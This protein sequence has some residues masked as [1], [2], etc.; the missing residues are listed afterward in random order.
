MIPKILTIKGLY[1]YSE[2]ATINFERLSQAHIF[3]IFGNVGSGKSTILEAMMLALYGEVPRLGHGKGDNRNFNMMNLKSNELSVDFEFEAAGKKYKS[4]VEAKRNVKKFE[5][6]AS[7][8]FR[9]YVWDTDAQAWTPL[10]FEP[11]EVIGLKLE[12]FTKTIIVPQNQ[13]QEFLQ[14]KDT[15]RSKM[16]SDLFNLERFD[17][18]KKATAIENRNKLKVAE[19]EFQLGQL[20]DVTKEKIDDI[21]TQLAD[22]ERLTADNATQLKEK[23]QSENAL[24]QLKKQFDTLNI[25]KNRLDE[26]ENRTPQYNALEKQ[27]LDFEYCQLHFQ[28]LIEQSESAAKSVAENT[29]LLQQNQKE[30]VE[31]ERVLT[32]TK[33]LHKSLQPQFDNRH[34]R[35]REA[36]ELSHIS[37][38]QKAEKA[39][40]ASSQRVE[41]GNIAVQ[42]Q[43]LI[44]EEL[45]TNRSALEAERAGLKS[46]NFI[47][48]GDIK[49]WF[50]K[51]NALKKEK[52]TIE[53]GITQFTESLAAIETNRNKLVA[54]DLPFFGEKYAQHISIAEALLM[55][56]KGIDSREKK[57]AESN[58]KMQ[59]ELAV[60]ELENLATQLNDGEPCPLCGSVHHPELMNTTNVQRLVADIEKE[61]AAITAHIKSL[62]NIG[63][64]L[65]T[66]QTMFIKVTQDRK[67]LLQQQA[68]KQ[69]EIAAH[70][71]LFIW[72]HF[73]KT[74][75]EAVN[76]A[77]V[78]ADLLVKRIE[79]LNKNVQEKT[80]NI[81]HEM[82][83][84]D[85]YEVVINGL[86]S[87]IAVNNGQKQ[88]LIQQ[89]QTL[90][91]SDFVDTTEDQ[92]LKKQTDIKEAVKLLALQFAEVEK[93]LEKRA[94]K[95]AILR[96]GIS[97]LERNKA[98][99]DAQLTT[100][101]GALEARLTAS[102]FTNLDAVKTI[103]TAKINVEFEKK[104]LADFRSESNAAKKAHVE[105]ALELTPKNY[106]I[107]NH[108]S[109]ITD[110]QELDEKIEHQNQRIGGLKTML[111]DAK[112]KL[113]QRLALEKE[114]SALDLRAKNISELK[115]LFYASGFVS[116]ASTIYLK[117]L[118]QNA[119]ERFERLTNYRLRLEVT[120]DNTFLVSD[121]LNDGKTR[122]VKTLSGGQT[123]QAALSLA[124]ALADN[125]QSLTKSP[126][127]FFF[128]DE[129]FG[130]LDKDSLHV[131]FETLKSLRRENRIVG[132]ISHVEEMQQEI[133]H[134]VRVVLDEEKG[135]QLSYH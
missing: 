44:I 5:E 47:E 100:A 79:E 25:L 96:G 127:N 88:T 115:R 21:K 15:E 93:Q 80:K 16:M 114:R 84:L 85:Q 50:S 60:L 130:S 128:L 43:R 24:T 78:N 131:V 49:N 26:F 59:H 4:I 28:H 76:I 119:N 8:R 56:K 121:I 19:N 27:L 37:T 108:Q 13:F 101:S 33:T 118:I 116:Y 29:A 94:E 39:I 64:Q 90:K 41:K 57:I 99:L 3:G 81:E 72:K 10:N 104:R 95:A 62:Q 12:H 117:S 65:E 40:L 42:K 30:F 87:E 22:L 55:L 17:L 46:P 6:V 32:E 83:K 38:I 66:L 106:S 51:L 7:P 135:S 132:V 71:R 89:L 23:Q 45:R 77:F 110:I 63:N 103:L 111:T 69:A 122:N 54:D 1:S 126:Q 124:L 113:T 9:R 107:E 73:S 102:V 92:L 53:R 82:T 20:G 105:L 120:A 11:A 74:D 86:N 98:K 129:G 123:F 52:E 134:H 34:N 36:E 58:K 125:I 48:L 18:A 112:N 75:E 14:L 61:I 2:E 35:L 109:L 31:N 133:E 67:L 70:E 91:L 97:E 68:D